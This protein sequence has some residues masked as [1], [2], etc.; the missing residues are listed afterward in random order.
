MHNKYET[1]N[2]EFIG[3][4]KRSYC[5]WNL[6]QLKKEMKKVY[7]NHFFILKNHIHFDMIPIK[8][9]HD[10]KVYY[11]NE[12]EYDIYF[13]IELD[14]KLKNYINVT[15]LDG[16][17]VANSSFAFLLSVTVLDEVTLDKKKISCN[18]ASQPFSEKRKNGI[19]L[20]VY[21]DDLLI[22]LFSSEIKISYD[23]QIVFKDIPFFRYVK[24]SITFQNTCPV[25]LFVECSI[26][27]SSLSES[28][29][30]SNTFSF[31]PF[32]ENRVLSFLQKEGSNVL[33]INN[34][35]EGERVDI[36][37]TEEDFN[38]TRY[39]LNETDL[40][41]EKEE[42]NWNETVQKEK[43]GKKTYFY[44]LPQSKKEFP[45][46]C[47]HH[48][49]RKTLQALLIVK[50]FC[51]EEISI[52]IHL[53]FENP[54][55]DS[56]CVLTDFK[57]TEEI[58]PDEKT[59]RK[60]DT[61]LIRCRG[62]S[63]KVNKNVYLLN[64][65]KNNIEYYFEKM[66]EFCQKRMLDDFSLKDSYE[67]NPEKG[68]HSIENTSNSLLYNSSNAIVC[69]NYKG[70]L[71]KSQWM[72][73][74]FICSPFNPNTYVS[75]YQMFVNS[76]MR[77]QIELKVKVEEPLV[78]VNT[79]FISMNHLLLEKTY[80]FIFYLINF[81]V[82][83]VHFEFDKNSYSSFNQKQEII[84]IV[85]SK[86]TIP[87]CYKMNTQMYKYIFRKN[88]KSKINKNNHSIHLEEISSN[89]EEDNEELENVERKKVP[90]L[91]IM[92]KL[93]L[94]YKEKDDEDSFFCSCSEI[95]NDS[96]S[97]SSICSDRPTTLEPPIRVLEERKEKKLLKE[98][99]I[100]KKVLESSME[101]AQWMYD[102]S[103]ME[104]SSESVQLEEIMQRERKEKI[105]KGNE[106]SFM[107]HHIEDIL[108]SE[109]KN[110]KK[111]MR[112][113]IGKGRGKQIKLY[114][115]PTLEQ[116]YNFNILCSIESKKEPLRIN[117]KTRVHR[118]NLNCYIEQLEKEKI[119]IPLPSKITAK[120]K[121]GDFE[122]ITVHETIDFKDT[123]IGKRKSC[124]LVLENG[125]SLPLF[126]KYCLHKNDGEIS[127]TCNDSC[128]SGH[129]KLM[130]TITFHP[131]ILQKYEN[132]FILNI[133]DFYLIHVRILAIATNFKIHFSF[134]HFDFGNI[135]LFPIENQVRKGDDIH[136]TE[137]ESSSDSS[138]L[139]SLLSSYKLKQKKKKN[140]LSLKGELQEKVV[141][142]TFEKEGEESET[143]VESKSKKKE[144]KG[145]KEK[146]K[147]KREEEKK[148]NEE[149]ASKEDKTCLE[150]VST[151]SKQEPL[152]VEEDYSHMDDEL[153]AEPESV[154]SLETKLYISNNNEEDC[155]IEYTLNEPCL[156]IKNSEG[157]H[158]FYLKK[159]S[160]ICLIMIFRP[161]EE[162]NYHFTI[163]FILNNEMNKI[164]NISIVG[165]ASHFK[166]HFLCENSNE[167]LFKD[168][169]ID[170][171]S[172][173]KFTLFNKNSEDI[174]F[175]IYNYKELEKSYLTFLRFDHGSQHHLKKREKKT[176]E[177]KFIPE[178]H[179][180][181]ELFLYLTIHYRNRMI[182]YK[183]TN[184]K[185]N[186][187]CYK[188]IL[189]E[190]F[191]TFNDSLENILEDS[192]YKEKSEDTSG[193]ELLENSEEGQTA[194]H[195]IDREEKQKVEELKYKLFKQVHNKECIKC[196]KIQLYNKGEMNAMFQIVL[197]SKYEKYL[198]FYPNKGI[199]FSLNTTYVYI[200]ADTSI[201]S[202]DLYI[203]DVVFDLSPK[204]NRIK[205]KINLNLLIPSPHTISKG[206]NNVPRKG[207]LSLEDLSLE[208]KEKEKFREEKQKKGEEGEKEGENQKEYKESDMN[209]TK[210]E[211]F[212]QKNETIISF[213]TD[214]R[215]E[216]Q[217]KIEINNDTSISFKTKFKFVLNESSFFSILKNDDIIKANESGSFSIIYKP[218][219]LL[220]KK[221]NNYHKKLCEKYQK[222]LETIHHIS[223]LI[224]YYPNNI[225][226]NY[227]LLGYANNSYEKKVEFQLKHKVLNSLSVKIKNWMNENQVFTVSHQCCDQELNLVKNESFFFFVQNKFELI[228]KE[229]KGLLFKCLSL[230]PGIVFVL[231]ILSNDKYDDAYKMLLRFE[232]TSSEIVEIKNIESNKKEIKKEYVCIYNPYNE[233]LSLDA[234]YTY[235]YIFMDRPIILEKKKN[236]KITIYFCIMKNET[237]KEVQ[238]TFT[239][240]Q[241]GTYQFK[242]ILNIQIEEIEEKFYFN[243]DLGG[244]QVNEISFTNFCNHPMNYNVSI[245]DYDEE[246]KNSKHI[247]ECVDSVS[248]NAMNTEYFLKHQ[249]MNEL[250]D[251]IKLMV[252]Y[253]PEHVRT[254]KA[255]VKLTSKEGIVYKGMIIG[256]SVIPK[257]KGPVFCFSS[258]STIIDFFNPFFKTE[259][260]S[261]K[262]DENFIVPYEK[263][264]I[265]AR[266][267]IQIP[268]KCKTNNATSGKLLIKSENE[269][270]WLYYLTGQ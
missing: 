87:S 104:S 198:T 26:L 178:K 145:K 177:I 161:T 261:L 95:Q 208:Q 78:F 137:E 107:H 154:N 46:Y 88:I 253:I 257:P 245:E 60:K 188:I 247:F 58:S 232:T 85:P 162:K 43:T 268:V 61:T 63:Y 120:D 2:V 200:F 175:Q 12:N 167:I 184:I 213:I 258:K 234:S 127:I 45:V 163:P 23:S 227:T 264:K 226:K 179:I 267:R 48:K 17:I 86:G 21:K 185:V 130:I 99:M 237:N 75:A 249:K 125:S 24:K 123:I 255:I 114:F 1:Y 28:E 138:S 92:N 73:I 117:F 50:I 136:L 3:N 76:E 19:D 129:S 70:T 168:Q 217:K 65:S 105:E 142:P 228:S 160:K 182:L 153:I 214:I 64:L 229:E 235:S 148:E 27:S 111:D 166:L 265:E 206:K 66:N 190:N 90:T 174:Y 221:S 102:E 18:F 59:I 124:V 5:Y 165:S 250:F 42:M 236:N 133:E 13:S 14:K 194:E 40:G 57:Y 195:I 67:F 115:T 96:D 187:V 144:K 20:Y 39:D 35:E 11:T 262:V 103:Y 121:K 152:L 186:S 79:P 143:A 30:V 191:I 118:M 216:A 244:V 25:K 7:D 169:P 54:P 224:V 110:W 151:S 218:T 98:D 93:E 211:I 72:P 113:M 6:H 270:T 32:E 201:V 220:K 248:V 116:F 215:K 150:K 157:N 56:L 269:M 37:D 122:I 100:Q 132:F 246:N 9:Q 260:F 223:K 112:N 69:S 207:Y 55:E 71:E 108:I 101:E 231:L 240:V 210:I 251:R 22:S 192:F 77:K 51:H 254:N 83:D 36:Q 8:Y 68:N 146:K 203:S 149:E 241:L 158:K 119:N 41:E 239:N 91:H 183:L 252:K 47:F 256:K 139:S 135:I 62:I 38:K 212:P 97:H 180:R 243:T 34:S 222:Y 106:C 156:T 89:A 16:S 199:L 230:N 33:D 159:K 53:E 80:C 170:K 225:M 4:L 44:I 164:V 94:E 84:R 49:F 74:H 81:D 126:Y 189:K 263:I 259:V 176:F 31:K 52:P 238:L 128:I 193:N 205:N 171:E 10:F 202:S 197:P 15:P 196:K 155:F 242:F 181:L 147:K 109:R 29:D 131:S 134:T 233:N 209:K 140:E 204:F 82:L 266:D 141:E 219:H 172:V 173:R